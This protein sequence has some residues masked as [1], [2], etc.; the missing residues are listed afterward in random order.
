V[1]TVA[2]RVAEL[3]GE[4]LSQVARASTANACSLFSLPVDDV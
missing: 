2:A 1:R 3:R 4:T